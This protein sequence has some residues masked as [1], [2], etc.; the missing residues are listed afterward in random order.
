M[1]VL[2]IHS[3]TRG[4]HAIRVLEGSHRSNFLHLSRYQNG[5]EDT[6]LNAYWIYE[7]NPGS[8]SG[9]WTLEIRIDGEPSGSHAFELVITEPPKKE[10]PPAPPNPP[11][12]DEVYGSVLRSLVWIYEIDEAGRRTDTSLGFVVGTDQ[13]ETAFQ[14]MDGALRVELEFAD[15][16]AV[17]AFQCEK[18]TYV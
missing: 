6:E 17:F 11:S 9:I 8:P 2:R 15:R 3:V 10:P 7:I 16:R 12:L 5:N 1:R 18:E 4:S 13:V 14:A